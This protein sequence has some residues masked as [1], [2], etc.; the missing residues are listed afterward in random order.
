MKHKLA[1]I[2]ATLF[3]IS[4]SAPASKNTVQLSEQAIYDFDSVSIFSG[5]KE[6]AKKKFLTAIDLYRNQ[7]NKLP[8]SITAF[9]ASLL[10]SPD[11]KT[12]FELGNALLDSRQYDE[13]LKAFLMAEK[14]DYNP[15]AN[16]MYK[17]AMAHAGLAFQSSDVTR[18]REDSAALHYMQISLQMGY[19]R[20]TDFLKD[21]IFNPGEG[22]NW[23]L[24]EVYK[25]TMSGNKD[26]QKMLWENFES[27]FAPVQLPLVINTVWIQQH[28]LD[29][30]IGYDYEKYVPEMRDNKFSREVENEYYYFA[31]IK[32]DSASIALM[33]AGKNTWL[34]DANGNRPTYFFLA[35]YSPTGKLI[36]KMLVAGQR[37]FTDPFK[38]LNLKENL[39]FEV[40]DYKNIFKNDPEK[41]GY[42]NNYVVK[43]ELLGS[44]NYR[45]APGGRFEKI[46]PPLA[47]K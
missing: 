13:S 5:D 38:V 31:K 27:G 43:S 24:M 14:L 29:E 33:Y 12:Y 20:P 41:G 36:D 26:P 32:N 42:E 39:N 34:E 16:V 44:T 1:Y 17:L 45:I 10:L 46:N 37:S 25:N 2:F 40:K 23:E 21:S 9:K 28:P 3:I 4:C 19:A 35:T 18:T 47:M 22:S 8:E 7:K 30:A 6:A 11:A 15:M